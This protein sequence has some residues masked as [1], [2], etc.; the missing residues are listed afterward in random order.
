[1]DFLKSV[2]GKVATGAVTLAVAA[3]GLAWYE[4]APATKH[5]VLSD[6]GRIIGW[7]LLALIL[8]WASFPLTAWVAKRDSNAA[9]AALVLGLTA[10]GAAVLA[11]L[12]GWAVHGATLWTVYAAAVLIAGVYNLFT[13]DWL[14]ERVG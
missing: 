1:M 3:G 2:G 10:V 5:A 12:F 8:P 4:T 14:A 7:T 13:C 6:A 11:L 9:G